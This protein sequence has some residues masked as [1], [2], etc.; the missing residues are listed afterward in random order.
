MINSSGS[1]G[2]FLYSYHIWFKL[3]YY[4][5]FAHRHWLSDIDMAGVDQQCQYFIRRMSSKQLFISRKDSYSIV[6]IL[7]LATYG[8]G[9]QTVHTFPEN[10][11]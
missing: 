2:F 4:I 7:L 1:C 6:I 10:E 11:T 9:V 3:Y 8:D 5:H